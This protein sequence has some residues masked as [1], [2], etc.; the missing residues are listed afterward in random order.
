[1]AWVSNYAS[2]WLTIP[3]VSASSFS[4]YILQ[5]EKLVVEGFVACLVFP[6]L[7]LKSFII[8]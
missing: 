5:M 2:H 4:L 6:I 7:N 8:T 1:M 3:S